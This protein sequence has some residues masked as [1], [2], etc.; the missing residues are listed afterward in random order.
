MV[1]Q[2]GRGVLRCVPYAAP[3]SPGLSI[4]PLSWFLFG[5]CVNLLQGP[6]CANQHSL[7]VFPRQIPRARIVKPKPL[8]PSTVSTLENPPSHHS[9]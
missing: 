3:S 1:V 2:H 7:L 6:N 4:G 5:S 9:P 8:N